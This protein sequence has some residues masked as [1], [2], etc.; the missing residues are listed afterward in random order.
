MTSQNIPEAPCDNKHMKKYT[1]FKTLN[2]SETSDNLDDGP[3]VEQSDQTALKDSPQ[4]CQDD[5]MIYHLDSCLETEL[6]ELKE[7]CV[8]DLERIRSF[9]K[10]I[11]ARELELVQVEEAE[12]RKTGNCCDKS[13]NIVRRKRTMPVPP[14]RETKRKPLVKTMELSSTET[15][16]VEAAMMK[17]CGV[18]LEKLMNHKHGWVFNEPVDVVALGISDY[19][20]VGKRPM[21]LGTIKLKLDKGVYKNPLDFAEDVRLT[22]RNALKYISIGEDVHT[23]A[24][25]LHD[26]FDKLFGPAYEKFEVEL[27]SVIVEQQIFGKPVAEFTE[28]QVQVS[29]Q[30]DTEKLM[31]MHPQAALPKKICKEAAKK[32]VSQQKRTV[33]KAKE[34]PR[35]RREMSDRE[36]VQIGIVL[37]DF[38]AEYMDEI[39]QIVAKRNS[40]MA[41]PDGDGEIELDVHA[42]DRET[43]WDLHKFVKLNLKAKQSNKFVKSSNSSSSSSESDSSSDSE[44]SSGS[45]SEDSVLDSA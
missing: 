41:T 2:P 8:I 40:Q 32:T 33:P 12:Y 11:E 22:F 45:D 29:S 9:V 30:P 19:Y 27:R 6:K 4:S 42:L 25:V 15:R 14:D 18:I 28:S 16:K 10:Q 1:S 20:K 44:N 43:M 38:A 13:S 37:Q 31:Q 7:Q 17:K 3:N 26:M 5:H 24:T 23:M 39:L 34:N 21:D 36:R 35:T